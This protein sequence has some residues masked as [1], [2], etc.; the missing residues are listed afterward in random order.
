VKDGEYSY[1]LVVDDGNGVFMANGADIIVISKPP[2]A[3][4]K[5]DDDVLFLDDKSHR[6]VND[7]VM[8]IDIVSDVGI[9]YARSFLSVINFN[10]IEVKTFTLKESAKQTIEWNG[11]EDMYNIS[12]PPGSYKASV[13]VFDIAGN[14]AQNVVDFL[15]VTQAPKVQASSVVPVKPVSSSKDA[16][17]T[18]A[19]PSAPAPAVVKSTSTVPAVS[20]TAI[21]TSSATPV[22]AVSKEPILGSIHRI[23][24]PDTN[25][26]LSADDKQLL[27]NI[28]A[29][30]KTNNEKI[31]V[32]GYT[33]NTP[34]EKAIKNLAANRAYLVRNYLVKQTK[35][36]QDKIKTIWH[37]VPRKANDKNR[38]VRIELTK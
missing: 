23:Y 16:K 17:K 2:K 14:T 15:I 1:E 37:P 12:L 3:A 31:R 5:L 34:K 27:D 28:S 36:P 29:R 10:G 6:L 35:F 8:H 9:D 13:T 32:D 24:F 21:A 20:K 25:L 4:I 7:V 11:V 22:N 18:S 26:E 38:C 30:A 19:S 33:D